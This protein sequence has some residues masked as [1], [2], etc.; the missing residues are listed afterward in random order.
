M[1]AV[2][3]YL[4]FIQITISRQRMKCVNLSVYVCTW[5][6]H[7]SWLFTVISKGQKVSRTQQRCISG[8]KLRAC[9]YKD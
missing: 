7:Y 8:G 5:V 2:H 1:L 9:L 4:V 3:V 6:R